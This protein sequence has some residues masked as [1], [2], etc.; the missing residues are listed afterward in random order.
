MREESIG[1]QGSQ[2]YQQGIMLLANSPATCS[3]SSSEMAVAW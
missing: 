1:S 2:V 3:C